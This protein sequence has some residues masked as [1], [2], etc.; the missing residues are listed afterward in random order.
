VS[1]YSIAVFLHIVGVL[2]LFAGIALEQVSLF[3]LH[4]ATTVSQ[5]RE[6]IGILGSLRRVD[7]PSGLAILA[8]GLY[9]ALERWGHQAWIGLAV[10][11]MVVM[12]VLGVAVTGRRAKRIATAIAEGD[13]SIST[14]LHQQ[15]DDPALR[16]SASLRAAIGLAVVFNMS[17][18]PGPAGSIAAVGAAVAL[19]V[20]AAVATIGRRQ[21]VIA[22]PHGAEA[23]PARR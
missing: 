9:M 21:S 5:V 6:W 12:A 1:I 20:L 17:L 23:R 19:G 11:A 2:G 3:N 15:L 10:I 13:G 18:K 7:A 22:Q 16:V 4:R 8:T 14:A